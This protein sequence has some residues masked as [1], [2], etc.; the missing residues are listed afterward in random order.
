MKKLIFV[1]FAFAILA[2][3]VSF[4]QDAAQPPNATASAQATQNPKPAK[5]PKTVTGCLQKGDQ[6]GEITLT[7]ADGRIYDLR[8][9]S[10]KLDEHIGHQ[11]TAT[12]TVRHEMK[13]EQKKEGDMEKAS[14]KE[15]VRDLNVTDLK[16]VSETCTK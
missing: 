11:V 16:M 6:P 5:S 3:A 12:G 8:S 10:V 14:S 1:S 7:A 4:A 2:S 15:A 9:D 13:A